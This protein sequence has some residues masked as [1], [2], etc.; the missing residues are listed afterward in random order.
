[1]NDTKLSKESFLAL[2]D[3]T[4]TLM[5]AY[6][7]ISSTNVW[8]HFKRNTSFIVSE[9]LATEWILQKIII[10]DVDDDR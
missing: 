8:S 4:H 1:M 10:H 2:F 9:R 7:P 5:S 6:S 3:E